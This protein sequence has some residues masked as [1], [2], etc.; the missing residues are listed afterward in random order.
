MASRHSI[1]TA[2][3]VLVASRRVLSMVLASSS[4][5]TTKLPPS[6]VF[7]HTLPVN[8]FFEAP[9]QEIT[10][11]PWAVEVRDEPFLREPEATIESEGPG[12]VWRHCE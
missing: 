12:I 2:V 9:T 3:V 1:S 11:L 6:W 4:T 7:Y 5:L 10:V 8:P